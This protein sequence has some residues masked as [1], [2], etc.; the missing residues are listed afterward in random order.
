MKQ[1]EDERETGREYYLGHRRERLI[2]NRRYL[3]TATEEDEEW[4]ISRN[5]IKEQYRLSKYDSDL[6][7]YLERQEEKRQLAVENK[8][9]N[10]IRARKKNK[11]KHTEDRLIV[12]RKYGGCIPKCDCCGED[13]FEFLAIDH[14][15]GGGNIHRKE[16]GAKAGIFRWLIRNN[17]PDGFR[18]LCHN[19]NLSLGFYGYCPH[20][21]TAIEKPAAQ[22]RSPESVLKYGWRL[23]KNKSNKT[24]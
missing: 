23:D 11:L 22:L 19:C 16:I 1:T 2:Y 18:I 9:D 8:I 20:N 24:P 3:G 6:R 21:A 17:F 4:M 15:K 5:L 13:R 10:Q 7:E 14:S 12:L